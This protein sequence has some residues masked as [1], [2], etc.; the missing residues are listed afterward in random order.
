MSLVGQRFGHLVIIEEIPLIKRVNS[1]KRLECLFK[2]DCGQQ[3]I[4]VFRYV[5]DSRSV[6]NCGCMRTIYFSEKVT[7]HGRSGKRE[8]KSWQKMKERCNCPA[9]H[10]YADYGGRGIS[11]DPKWE[12][13]DGFW[14]EMSEGYRDDLELDRIDPNGHYCKENCQWAT[15]S[16]QAFNQ[17]KRKT[18]TSGRTGV[19]QKKNGKWWAEI[20]K[21]GETE[22][23]GTF[24][25]FEEAVTAREAKELEYY[26]FTKS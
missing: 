25:S 6:P 13:F 5:R 26:G 8:Y 17:R 16:H 14:S 1:E 3:I 19:Y 21:E 4:R 22:W 23:L 15:E 18:N 11:Y 20:Q 2:C 10:Y 24:D 12:T 9:S 7:Q